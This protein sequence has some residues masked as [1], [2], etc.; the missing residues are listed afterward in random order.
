MFAEGFLKQFLERRIDAD[1]AAFYTALM[2][3]D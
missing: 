2:I 1:F 3:A